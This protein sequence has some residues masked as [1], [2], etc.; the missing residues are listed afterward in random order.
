VV[1]FNQATNELNHHETN[2]ISQNARLHLA[3]TDVFLTQI[4]NTPNFSKS[5]IILTTAKQLLATNRIIK[6]ATNNN[7]YGNDK[8][9]D[10]LLTQIEQVLIEISNSS[11][12]QSNEYMVKYNKELLFKVKNMNAQLKLNTTAI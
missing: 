12:S 3:Q 11:S 2:L 4:K 6:A 8:H 1:G 5:A 7:S 10:H 9:M